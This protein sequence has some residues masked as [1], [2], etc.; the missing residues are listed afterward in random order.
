MDFKF[1]I[2]FTSPRSSNGLAL[3]YRIGD[4]YLPMLKRDLLRKHLRNPDN[5]SI[6]HNL[7]NYNDSIVTEVSLRQ[8]DAKSVRYFSE[9]LSRIFCNDGYIRIEVEANYRR[10]MLKVTDLEAIETV[11]IK[12]ESFLLDS[13]TANFSASKE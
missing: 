8:T 13:F 4:R 7:K 10:L 2:T 6:H 1:T 5:F 9:H 11:L 12:A 3:R